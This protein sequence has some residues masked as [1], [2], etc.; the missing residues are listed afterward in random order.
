MHSPTQDGSIAIF[1]MMDGPL[2]VESFTLRWAQV[3]GNVRD[4]QY[5]HG[6]ECIVVV[7]AK[8]SAV[9]E[10]CKQSVIAGFVFGQP[11][12]PWIPPQAPQNA[13]LSWWQECFGMPWH[14]RIPHSVGMTLSS[15]DD[16]G[17]L[18]FQK[19]EGGVIQPRIGMVFTSVHNVEPFIGSKKYIT[20]SFEGKDSVRGNIAGSRVLQ[21]MLRTCL[22]STLPE[23]SRELFREEPLGLP[24]APC[25]DVPLTPNHM[26]ESHSMLASEPVL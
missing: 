24:P 7:M 17:L 22:V 2:A 5:A 6:R 16:E 25:Y 13:R 14:D 26:P 12:D 23:F 8:H 18:V 19:V 4:W 11:E 10:W 9:M 20:L 15:E 1:A 3:R 21:Y